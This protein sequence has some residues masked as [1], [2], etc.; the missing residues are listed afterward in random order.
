MPF[1]IYKIKNNFVNMSLRDH[2]ALPLTFTLK[3][4]STIEKFSILN[5]V[6]ISLTIHVEKIDSLFLFFFYLFYETFPFLT[7]LSFNCKLVH[8]LPPNLS[9]EF[10]DRWGCHSKPEFSNT[11]K[12]KKNQKFFHSKTLPL[13]ESRVRAG[14]GIC[15]LCLL[16]KC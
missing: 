5:F 3:L 11:T 13:S 10:K 4:N 15:P 6:K 1:L 7:T 12:K 16:T 8:W 2:H 9:V 14:Y